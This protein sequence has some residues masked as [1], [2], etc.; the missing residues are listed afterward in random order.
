MARG[1]LCFLD[2]NEIERIDATA[3]RTLEEVG[4]RI[5][6]DDVNLLLLDAGAE[7]SKDGKRV[8]IPGRMIDDALSSAPESVLLAGM[9]SKH[10]ITIPSA[11]GRMFAANGG[12]GVRVTD[13]ITGKIWPSSTEDLRKFAVL[14]EALP[15][16]DFF[17][18]MV[19]ALEQPTRRKEVVE[20][21]VSMEWTTKHIQM[22]AITAEQART[23]VKMGAAVAGGEDELAKRPMFSAVQCPI[24]PLTFEKGLAEA[25][26]EFARAGI[27]V[28][29][30]AA[31]V[32]GLTSPITL[33]GTTAQVVAENLASLVITQTAAKG[34]PF[35][36]SSDSCP[37]DLKTGSIDYGALETP[38]FRTAAG[39]MG[40]HY[41][42]PKMVAGLGLESLS[43]GMTDIWQGVHF[44]INQLLVPSD[45]A[46]GFGGL[47][48]AAGASYEQM[49]L[50]AWVW[51][52]AREFIRDFDADDAAISFDT[53]Q[54]AGLDGNF[55]GKKHTSERFRKE[56][57]STRM[58]ETALRERLSGK[59]CGHALKIAA[60][61]ANDILGRPP[62]PKLTPDRLSELDRIIDGL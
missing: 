36:F 4:V 43:S 48:Q 25:Q 47:E 15:Q 53:I 24:S 40:E 38:L 52:V 32:A 57:V 8:L 16:I 10:D 50:D 1:R 41:G 19:G 5:H 22:G 12:E 54:A 21:R 35:V 11:D 27:P 44:M 39:Q 56:F 26:V 7:R 59:G 46:S 13:Q 55:L 58:P 18:P 49:V 61:A 29:S 6:S 17:W 45:L 28:V 42:L 51:D 34:A 3:R 2:R 23:M 14:V 37:G 20:L 9:D 62:E 30:M 60:D 33:S 31:T